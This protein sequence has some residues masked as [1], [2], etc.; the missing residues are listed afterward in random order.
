MGEACEICET[1][2]AVVEVQINYADDAER[3]RA[4]MDC[5]ADIVGAEF[6]EVI[7]VISRG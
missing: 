3:C 6:A 5:A 7:E 2:E 1:G 4:C